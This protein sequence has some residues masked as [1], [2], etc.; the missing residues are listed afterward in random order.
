MERNWSIRPYRIGD[1]HEI[2]SL[3]KVVHPEREYNREKWLRWWTWQYKENPAGSSAIWIAEDNGKI[4]GQYALIS[5]LVKVYDNLS[6]IYQSVDTMTHPNYR[7][8]GM[9]IMLARAAYQSI[10]NNDT[11]IIFGF[12]NNQSLP[13]F[14]GELNFHVILNIPLIVKPD[15]KSVV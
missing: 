15:R 3:W 8:Q 7:R 6:I 4:V 14:I 12:P 9:F 11:H 1:E 10:E 2:L 13:G 5:E